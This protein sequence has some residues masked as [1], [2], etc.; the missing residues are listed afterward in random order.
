MKTFWKIAPWLSR[1]ILVPPTLAIMMS[2]L[3]FGSEGGRQ[4]PAEPR[5]Q[6]SFPTSDGGLIYGKISNSVQRNY[7]CFF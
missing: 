7:R 4:V 1:L 2:V 3:V 6:V 5:E